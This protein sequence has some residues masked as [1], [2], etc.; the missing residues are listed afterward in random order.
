MSI[1]EFASELSAHRV[2]LCI[3]RVTHISK[4]GAGCENSSHMFR[5]KT[6]LAVDDHP[7]FETA[8]FLTVTM[9]DN[10]TKS[11]YFNNLLIKHIYDYEVLNYRLDTNYIGDYCYYLCS[12]L[13]ASLHNKSVSENLESLTKAAISSRQPIEDESCLCVIEYLNGEFY[14][15]PLRSKPIR[16]IV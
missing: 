3:T 7:L 2:K 15:E 11:I 16:K 8:E 9:R 14:S 1:M 10:V 6:R 13:S 12:L 5:T 4:A